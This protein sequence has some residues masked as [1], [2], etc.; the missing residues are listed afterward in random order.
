MKL[1][2]PEYT[3][4]SGNGQRTY[5]QQRGY[6]HWICQ[7]CGERGCERIP[8]QADSQYQNNPGNPVLTVCERCSK[9]GVNL[10]MIK[11]NGHKPSKTRERKPKEDN[12]QDGHLE[13][14]WATYLE[15]ARRFEHKAQA[16]DREDLREDIILRLAQVAS[17]NGHKPFTEASMVRTASLVLKEYWHD[18][19]R[20]PSPL[21]LDWETENGDGDKTT[22]A[23]VIADDEAIDLEAWQDARQWLLGCPEYLIQIASKR[24]E[25]KPLSGSEREYLR[26]WREKELQRKQSLLIS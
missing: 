6:W 22:L 3:T 10:A 17:R 15:I 19:Q 9:Y 12:G 11:L 20:K 25:G 24:V 7:V 2:H 4:A 18:K 21:S 13:E 16:Q 1:D 5:N 26:Y 14:P 8:D 23:D